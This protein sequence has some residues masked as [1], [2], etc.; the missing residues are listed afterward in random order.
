MIKKAL[1]LAS[2]SILVS[3]KTEPLSDDFAVHAKL[4]SCV[5]TNEMTSPVES[6]KASMKAEE[7]CL[8]SLLD[9]DVLSSMTNILSPSKGGWWG[10]PVLG[11]ATRAFLCEDQVPDDGY[12]AYGY[13]LFTRRPNEKNRKRYEIIYQAYTD[14]LNSLSSYDETAKKKLMPT[15]WLIEK[16][17]ESIVSF[18]FNSSEFCINEFD[19]PRAKEMLARR[20]FGRGPVLIAMVRPF[21]QGNGKGEIVYFDL[22]KL[23][24]ASLGEAMCVWGNTISRDSAYWNKGFEIEKFRMALKDILNQNS[25]AIISAVQM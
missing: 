9:D 6:N 24:D 7:I 19:Y 23:S 13:L 1:L 12:G 25:V 10:S 11:I 2:L 22:S 21:E 14:Q 4:A 3:C 16:T 17:V 15:Y 5:R 20:S 18:N 8:S